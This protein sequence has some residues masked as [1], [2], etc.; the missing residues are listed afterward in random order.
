MNSLPART[1]AAASFG[2]RIAYGVGLLLAPARLSE[3]WLGST[4]S[5]APVKVPLRALAAREIVL[6][7]AALA[8]FYADAPLRP[9]LLAAAAGDLTDVVAT[10]VG[11]RELPDRAAPLVLAVGGGSAAVNVVIAATLDS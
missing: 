4:V 7:A 1:T 9:W 2:L 8:A 5:T 3:R 11:R 6:S 10:L